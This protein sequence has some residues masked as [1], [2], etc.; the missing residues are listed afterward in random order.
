[1]TTPVEL[2]FWFS[3]RS[4]ADAIAEDVLAVFHQVD[5]SMSRYK[6]DSELSAINRRAADKPVN[7]SPDLFLVLK[8]AGEVAELSDGAFDVS[9]GSVGFLYDYREH[10]QPSEEDIRSKLGHINYQDIILDEAERTVFYRQQGLLVDLG[11]IA[12]GFAVDLG[13]ERLVRAGVRHA[14]LS[15]GGDLRLLGDKR[16]SPWL[17]GVRDPRSGERNAVVLP[18]ANVA[19]STSGDYERF[20]INDQ[21]ERVHHI[22][23]PGTGKSVR[24]VQSVTIIGDDALTTDGL[25]TAVFVLG[26]EKGLEMI[27][28]LPGIDAIIID[29]KRVMHFSEG[30]APPES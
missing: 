9:F 4:A 1:M 18:L 3:D 16:G 25:S 5:R 28:R 17:V 19:I 11:G 6:D 26:P 15:A 30:L 10:Q 8:K 23:S 22:L 13:I 14:R 12:K 29:D 21:G 20:F 27:E 7:V 2:E 24:G